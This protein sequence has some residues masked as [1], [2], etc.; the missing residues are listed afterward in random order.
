MDNELYTDFENY[1]NENEHLISFL[2]NENSLLNEYIAPIIKSLTYLMKMV[3][4]DDEE[5][6]NDFLVIFKYGFDYLFENLEQIKLYLRQLNN[7]YPLLDKMSLYI[8]IV[9]D[10]EELKIEIDKN[11]DIEQDEKMTD[12]NRI[13]DALEFF[14]ENIVPK[15][16]INEFELDKFLNLYYELL[17]KYTEV[18]LMSDA[19][20]E[21]CATYGI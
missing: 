10:L 9:F 1:V 14:E 18:V 17:E 16:V 19:F 7:D 13:D 6:T 4:D 15:V 11:H 8:K 3:D 21:Y 5:P 12:I 20:I 2:E